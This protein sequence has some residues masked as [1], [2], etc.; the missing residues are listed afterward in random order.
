MAS[1]RREARVHRR[2]SAERALRDRSDARSSR[3]RQR[4][5]ARR[6]GRLFGA[7]RGAARAGIKHCIS[8]GEEGI[9]APDPGFFT[10]QRCDASDSHRSIHEPT[11]LASRTYISL[12]AE[13]RCGLF[14]QG[15]VAGRTGAHACHDLT[16]CVIHHF[17]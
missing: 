7:L 17:I 3:S 12:A 5:A 14:C 1:A 13:Q 10:R 9:A 15:P 6:S 11:Q 16:K 8:P 2:R 4:G